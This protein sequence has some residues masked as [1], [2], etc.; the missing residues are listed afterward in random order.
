[1]QSTKKGAIALGFFCFKNPSISVSIVKR[2]ES[3]FWRRKMSKLTLE[4]AKEILKKHV[5]QGH[6]FSHAEAVSAAM[7]KMAVH[8]GEDKEYW[9]AIGYLH[10]VDFEK[11]PEEHCHHV[12]EL[13]EGEGV[14]DEDI[15]AIIS[16]G[17]GICT[18]E[19]EPLSNLEKS[20]YTVDELTGIVMA[21]ALM[22]PTGIVGMDLKSLKKKFKDKKF[23]AKCSRD[24][25]KQGMEM[26]DVDPDII[27][28]CCMDGMSEHMENLGIGP[29]EQ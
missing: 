19:C 17:Y 15:R 4:K 8:F 2:I 26:L 21:N 25:I 29:K 12:R 1:M 23:A 18:D 20:L 3:R 13:L 11:Y 14:D 22:R 28:Q 16:H 7:G 9:E 27:M 5:T 24:V 6:L 10:D